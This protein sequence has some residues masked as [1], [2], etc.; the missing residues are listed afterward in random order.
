MSQL[1]YEQVAKIKVFGVGGA[2]GNAVNR[3]YEDGVQG[4]EFFIA[5]TDMQVLNV[6]PIENKI[7]LGRELTKGL[8]AGGVPEVGRKAAEESEAEIR[9][10]M[11]GSNMVFITTGLGG[12][13]G[14]GAAPLFAKIAKEMDALT[15]G[16]VTKPFSFEGRDRTENA[17]EGLKNLKEHVDS[18]IIVSNDQLLQVVGR[19]PLAEAFREADNVL[20]QGIQTITDLI[21]IPALINLDFA[22]IKRIMK[23]QGSALIGIGM[24]QGEDKANE[25]AEKAIQSPL[26]EAQI[27]GAT[28]AIINVTGG[29][30]ISIQDANDAVEYVKKAAG[31]DMDVTFGIAINENIG[32]AIIVTVIATGFDKGGPTFTRAGNTPTST[33]KS[34]DEIIDIP[35]DEIPGFFRK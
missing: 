17:N 12:G 31:G 5:N 10:A 28:S 11:E 26:L 7:V 15:I 29:S 32:D 1:V 23:G 21:A 6:S 33:F 14:T 34:M 35:D 20:R 24:A 2:G 25:A 13:T 3:M 19:I 18:L 22:D 27:S 8:G 30:A 9:K 16:I 4:V